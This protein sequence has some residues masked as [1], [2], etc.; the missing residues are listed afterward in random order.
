MS[1]ISQLGV[2]NSGGERGPGEEYDVK[3]EEAEAEDGDNE[4]KLK[5]SSVSI[6][7]L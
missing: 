6:K 7:A 3:E 1:E 4:A 2:V 5:S